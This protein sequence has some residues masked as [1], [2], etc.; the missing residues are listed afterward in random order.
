MK[1]QTVFLVKCYKLFHLWV[2]CFVIN[3]PHLLLAH[4]HSSKV[5]ASFLVKYLKLS[6]LFILVYQNLMRWKQTWKVNLKESPPTSN[7][8]KNLIWIQSL[9]YLQ[10]QL[11]KQQCHM[12]D[13]M[14][15]YSILFLFYFIN[16]K[17]IVS[18]CCC[19]Y[20]L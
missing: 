16:M 12:A 15:K 6:V 17:I 8:I 14:S 11:V 19:Y 2:G 13:P 7:L 4:D 1:R 18:L 20:N 10:L 3:N 5:D 9:T